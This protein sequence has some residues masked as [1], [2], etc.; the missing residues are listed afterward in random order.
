M[1]NGHI[2]MKL[3]ISH[4]LIKVPA[5]LITIGVLVFGF[6]CVGVFSKSMHAGMVDN[7][8]SLSVKSEKACCG[9]STLHRFDVS[10]NTL[11]VPQNVRDSL[12][13]LV[14][15]LALAFGIRRLSFW[16]TS[17]NTNLLLYRL[18]DRRNPDLIFF[19]PLK[20]AFA[21]GILNPK[22]Y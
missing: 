16:N 18:Y 17:V 4:K 13:W 14:L 9:S 6:A 1:Y 11:S 20:L 12:M 8:E 2:G 19:N 10:K 22:V 5:V 3:S 21:R 15:A 7:T